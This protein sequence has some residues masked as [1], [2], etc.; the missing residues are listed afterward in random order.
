[1]RWITTKRE[2][3]SKQV[4]SVRYGVE[5]SNCKRFQ[6]EP[7]RYCAD[8]GERYDGEIIKKKEFKLWQ[9]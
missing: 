5:C 6:D 2:K 1:M 7:T 3:I 4:K 8:C 9:E